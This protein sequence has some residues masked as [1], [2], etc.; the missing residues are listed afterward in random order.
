M[1]RSACKI[2]KQ[3][4]VIVEITSL[5]EKYFVSVEDDLKY[6]EQTLQITNN[7]VW[8]VLGV[9]TYSVVLFTASKGCPGNYEPCAASKGCPGNYN[10]L[11][12]ASKGCPG[13]YNELCVD[14]KF[15][16]K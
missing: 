6:N 7:N 15:T 13:N 8:N 5:Q 12:A 3:I 2:M 14:F 11:C 9:R 10:E 4:R 1:K 16:N